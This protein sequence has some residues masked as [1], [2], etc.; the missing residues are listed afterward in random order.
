MSSTALHGLTE[1]EFSTLSIKA[2]EAKE[3]A[4]CTL[5]SPLPPI[6]S[7]I[8]NSVPP[9]PYSKFRVGCSLLFADGSIYTGCNVENASYPVGICAERTAIS[10]AVSEGKR[11]IKALGVSTDI[12]P[13]A[14][15]CGKSF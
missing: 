14:S 10:K 5:S 6:Q 2:A 11:K 3:A 7:P 1:A 9:G 8:S 15:P 12:A 4:Y 13:P